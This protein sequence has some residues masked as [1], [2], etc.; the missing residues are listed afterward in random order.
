MAKQGRGGGGFPG[1]GGGQP[2]MQKLMQ[3]AQKMQ[4]QMAVAQQ[5]LSEA[6]V[7]GSAGNGLVTATVS[8][9]GELLGLVVKPEVVDPDDVDTLVDL[10][11]YAVKD[12]QTKAAELA[13]TTMGPLTAGLGGGLPF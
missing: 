4:Q 8:G 2:N 5:E 3:Q 13:E 10:V 9:S 11:V 6:Q 12:A 1:G 7:E